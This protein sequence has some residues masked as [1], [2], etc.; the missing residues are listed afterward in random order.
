[1]VRGAAKSSFRDHAMVAARLAAENALTGAMLSVTIAHGK[2]N[3]LFSV[4]QIRVIRLAAGIGRVADGRHAPC[5]PAPSPAHWSALA[6]RFP[7]TRDLSQA[8]AP[9]SR[10][11]LSCLHPAP[12]RRWDRRAHGGNVVDQAQP[13]L[14]L[15]CISGL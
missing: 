9:I 7:F 8:M 10:H 12:D 14:A 11:S 6:S 13:I 3:C 5:L 2:R 1:M 4:H 15:G